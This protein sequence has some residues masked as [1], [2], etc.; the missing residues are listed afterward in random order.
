MP[1]WPKNAF[2]QFLSLLSGSPP[3]FF[4]CDSVP[5]KNVKKY[6][7]K[8]DSLFA[9]QLSMLLEVALRD[10]S[11]GTTLTSEGLFPAV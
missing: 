7:A 4:P 9:M 8:F 2:E 11:L 5:R 3:C 10:E 1:L 6:R